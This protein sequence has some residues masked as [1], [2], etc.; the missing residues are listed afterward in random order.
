M[1]YEFLKIRDADKKEITV[2]KHEMADRIG[3][4]PEVLGRTIEFLHD[5]GFIRAMIRLDRP[6]DIMFS[7]LTDKVTL[8]LYPKS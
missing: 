6:D 1:V 2:N 5:C 7:I 8:E 4:D 3:L